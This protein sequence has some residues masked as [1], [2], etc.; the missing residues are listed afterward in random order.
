MFTPTSL[1]RASPPRLA[2][3]GSRASPPCTTPIHSIQ[4]EASGW[5]PSILHRFKRAKSDHFLF[6]LAVC[7]SIGAGKSTLL[8]VFSHLSASLTAAAGDDAPFRINVQLEPTDEFG[9]VLKKFYDLSKDE[10][11]K[12]NWALYFQLVVFA[13]QQKCAREATE[14]ARAQRASGFRGMLVVLQER[15]AFDAHAVFMH[16]AVVNGVATPEAASLL[17]VATASEWVPDALVYVRTSADTCV[18]RE[19]ARGRASEKN[20]DDSYVRQVAQRYDEVFGVSSR[21]AGGAGDAGAGCKT[22]EE[23]AKEPSFVDA[24]TR[25][26]SPGHWAEKT[27]VIEVDNEEHWDSRSCHAAIDTV[28][29]YIL[30]QCT[31]PTVPSYPLPATGLLPVPFPAA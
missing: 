21:I 17:Q 31:A 18:A 7:G 16:L 30:A 6:R 8:K 15:C 26:H 11:L 27:A 4:E 9:P 23:L 5:V 12:C 24:H 20:M 14:W 19:R 25:V 29:S 28:L 10:M 1:P 13:H 2:V 22:S 3:S